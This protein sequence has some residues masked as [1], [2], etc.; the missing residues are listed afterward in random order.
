[1]LALNPP[2]G[3]YQ[4]SLPQPTSLPSSPTLSSLFLSPSEAGVRIPS[5]TENMLAIPGPRCQCAA[6]SGLLASIAGSCAGC[7]WACHV[8]EPVDGGLVTKQSFFEN[9]VSTMVP[10]RKQCAAW[11]GPGL[12]GRGTVGSGFDGAPG[13]FSRAPTL[14]FRAG[15]SCKLTFLRCECRRCLKAWSSLKE[16]HKS[17]KMLRSNPAPQRHPFGTGS[18]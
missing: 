9:M 3:N 15:F 2:S 14:C 18:A 17:L 12:L 11:R 7:F 1:M 5:Q 13:L 6:A 4:E 8:A 10:T 16:K